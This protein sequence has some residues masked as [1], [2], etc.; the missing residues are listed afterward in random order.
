MSCPFLTFETHQTLR[1]EIKK[2]YCTARGLKDVL[3]GRTARKICLKSGKCIIREQREEELGLK[4]IQ[5]CAFE[6]KCI[7]F[8]EEFNCPSCKM[9][10]VPVCVNLGMVGEKFYCSRNFPENCSEYGCPKYVYVYW[11][12]LENYRL[13]GKLRRGGI[14]EQV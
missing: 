6:K 11:K 5:W 2:Y 10:L 9:L 13:F 3:D 4:D 7:N 1:G 12:E 14:N 8:N